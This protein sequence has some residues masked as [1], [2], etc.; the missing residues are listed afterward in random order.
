HEMPRT[1]TEFHAESNGGNPTGGISIRVGD[2]WIAGLELME[3]SLHFPFVNSHR[4]LVY[5]TL[6]RHT[7]TFLFDPCRL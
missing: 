3:S 5:V 7:W 4:L 2:I 1:R 6:D